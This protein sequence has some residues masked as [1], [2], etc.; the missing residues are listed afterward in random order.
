MLHNTFVFLKFCRLELYILKKYVDDLFLAGDS[1]KKGVCWN[2]EQKIFIWSQEQEENDNR[3][4]AHRTLEE[5]GKMASDLV[6]CLRFTWDTAEHNTNG[7]MPVLDTQ[8]W[9]EIQPRVKRTPEEMD[10]EA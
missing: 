5:I 8:L 1:L 3:T 9:V 4:S 7:R 6:N 2:P 10:P